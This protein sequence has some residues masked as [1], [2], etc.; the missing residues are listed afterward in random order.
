MNIWQE[1]N[2]YFTSGWKSPWANTDVCFSDSPTAGESGWDRLLCPSPRAFPGSSMFSYWSTPNILISNP[3]QECMH[4]E[5][6]VHLRGATEVCQ[7]HQEDARCCL[8]WQHKWQTEFQPSARKSLLPLSLTYIINLIQNSVGAEVKSMAND[9]S[10]N[11]WRNQYWT[12]ADLSSGYFQCYH[13]FW[14]ARHREGFGLQ[15]KFPT[16]GTEVNIN[17]AEVTKSNL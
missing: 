7:S 5:M 8:P 9:T 4:W 17:H 15:N 13:V 6:T 14:R 3:V 16:S 10:S 1:L 11:P 12:H 2:I